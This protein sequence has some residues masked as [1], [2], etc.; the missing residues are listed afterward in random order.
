MKR[1]LFISAGV[2]S[3]VGIAG[4]MGNT[5]SGTTLPQEEYPD[6]LSQ[7]GLSVDTLVSSNSPFLQTNSVTINI[8]QTSGNGTTTVTSKI[9]STVPAYTLQSVNNFQGNETMT[10]QYFDGDVLYTNRN[11]SD[12]YQTEQLTFNKQREYYVGFI[13]ELLNGVSFSFHT[14]TDQGVLEYQTQSMDDFS[15]TSQFTGPDVVNAV[16]TV[17]LTKE[18]LFKEIT[19][20][21]ERSVGNESDQT[22]IFTQSIQFTNY[23]ETTFSEPAWVDS[24]R[25][26]A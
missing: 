21:V 1:R 8:E 15:D 24:A 16:V 14:V 10:K 11:S 19:T 7:T 17:R 12:E 9:D 26:Q 5:Q 22:D 25:Q 20:E 13:Q 6:G 18:G 3:V 4:C 23:D 2:L